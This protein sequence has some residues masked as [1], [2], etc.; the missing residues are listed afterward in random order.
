MVIKVIELLRCYYWVMSLIIFYNIL[1][2]VEVWLCAKLHLL[3]LILYNIS[4]YFI[5]FKNET[6]LNWPSPPIYRNPPT[7]QQT[8]LTALWTSEWLDLLQINRKVARSRVWCY[9]VIDGNILN[10]NQI[11]IYT[12]TQYI[13]LYMLLLRYE[14]NC[15]NNANTLFI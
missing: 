1:G 12:H 6:W 5:T 8:S 2:L 11:Y 10:V 3:C 15:A 13:E 9:R 4:E 14:N 7:P